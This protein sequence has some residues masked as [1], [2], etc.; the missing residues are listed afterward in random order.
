MLPVCDVIPP[1]TAPVATAGLIALA[2]ACFSYQ[3]TLDPAALR[4]LAAGRG[5]VPV[6]FSWPDTLTSLAFHGGWVHLVTNAF[7]LWLFGP[8]VESAIGRARFVLL[9]TGSGIAGGAV[10]ASAHPWSALPLVGA[11]AA[12]IGVMGAYLVLYPKSRV[13]TLLFTFVR[14][15]LIELPA[16]FFVSVWF[17]LQLLNGAGSLGSRFVDGA[18]AFWANIG[19]LAAGV[20]GGL[21]A[22]FG[23]RVL[24]RHWGRDS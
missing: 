15:E 8:S 14:F 13:L 20:L 23:M 22:R 9:C 5:V 21:Y 19:G 7:F 11:G 1:R 3:L 24:R 10:H 12:V 2:A 6:E 17:L 4:W 16:V 18:G